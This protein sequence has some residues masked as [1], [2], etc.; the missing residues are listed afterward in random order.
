MLYVPGCTAITH[1]ETSHR[2]REYGLSPKG[3]LKLLD[4]SCSCSVDCSSSGASRNA[5]LAATIAVVSA[6]V[7]STV[8]SRSLASNRGFHC[9]TH[10]VAMDVLCFGHISPI[11]RQL[12]CRSKRYGTNDRLERPLRQ[13]FDMPCRRHILR[14]MSSTLSPQLSDGMM[15]ETPSSLG[16]M[17]RLSLMA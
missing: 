1:P 16:K 17:M 5:C 7:S 9:H 11:G 12:P 13:R 4:I 10:V 14:A 2:F 6:L 8:N 3:L 15:T